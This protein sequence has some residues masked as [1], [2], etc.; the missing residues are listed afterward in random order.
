MEH[1]LFGKPV[2][3]FPDHA[4][5]RIRACLAGAEIGPFI[6]QLRHKPGSTADPSNVRLIYTFSISDIYD[7]FCAAPK[8]WLL[9]S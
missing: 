3:T 7:K 9:P 4:L 5:K 6:E 8:S 2:S 1:D